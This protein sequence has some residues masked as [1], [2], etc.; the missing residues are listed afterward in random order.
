[1]KK[2]RHFYSP[3][4]D[5]CLANVFEHYVHCYGYQE[6]VNLMSDIF[7]D[8]WHYMKDDILHSFD[9]DNQ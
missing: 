5:I 9:W 8:R 6:A 3:C 4:L 2:H 7:Q 1:M